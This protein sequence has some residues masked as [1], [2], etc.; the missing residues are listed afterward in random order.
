MRAARSG[1]EVAREE[2]APIRA[3]PRESGQALAEMALAVPILLL[4]VFGM[5]EFGS[6][7]RS[8]QVITNAARE[9]AR[10]AVMPPDGGL[11]DPGE[12]AVLEIVEDVMTSGGLEFDASYVSFSCDDSAGLCEGS[13]GASEEVRI[14]YPHEFVLVGPLMDL[15]CGGCGADDPGTII[16]STSSVMRSEG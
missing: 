5:I 16:L 12:G 6:A 8:Y 4:L 14:E 13:R 1:R 3:R 9:G 7:W 15:A 10:R 2:R 11:V